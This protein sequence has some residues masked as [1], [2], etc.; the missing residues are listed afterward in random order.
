MQQLKEERISSIQESIFEFLPLYG[1]VLGVQ[2]DNNDLRQLL[3]RSIILSHPSCGYVNVRSVAQITGNTLQIDCLTELLKQYEL[4]VVD[5]VDDSH[6][7]GVAQA[8][9]EIPEDTIVLLFHNA[10]SHYVTQALRKLHF[11]NVTVKNRKVI[12]S[13]YQGLNRWKT[14]LNRMLSIIDNRMN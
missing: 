7:Q 10:E 13:T 1:G 8:L 3:P 11:T 14:R 5:A 2:V 4:V 6:L 12:A 9:S